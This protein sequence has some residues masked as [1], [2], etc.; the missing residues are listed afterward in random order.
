MPCSWNTKLD[1]LEVGCTWFGVSLLILERTTF[2]KR[3]S[4]KWIKSLKCFTTR[5]YAIRLCPSCQVKIGKESF[6]FPQ[7]GDVN[8][9]VKT[10][11]AKDWKNRDVM[12]QILKEEPARCGKSLIENISRIFCTSCHKKFIFRSKTHT[13]AFQLLFVVVSASEQDQKRFNCPKSSTEVE[14]VIS[15]FWT[16]ISKIFDI[17]NDSGN[18]KYLTKLSNLVLVLSKV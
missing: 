1:V 2:Q 8:R 16:E 7:L 9:D 3:A 12:V 14:F 13:F 4:L 15:N 6:G 18:D 5:K 11:T 17:V 10:N